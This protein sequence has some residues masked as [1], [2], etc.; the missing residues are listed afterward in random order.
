M[1]KRVLLYGTMGDIGRTALENLQ[2]HGLDAALVD[3]PQN[4]FR[5]VWGYCRGLGKA[6]DA[7]GPDCVVPVGNPIAMARFR[8]ENGHR[9]PGVEFCV[10]SEEKVRLLDSK[11]QSYG[12]AERLGILQPRRFPSATAVPEGVP[13][14]FKR[15]VS[16][17]G[18]GVHLPR[19]LEA[20]AQLIAHQ[21]PG[22]PY[23]IEE[24]I[25]GTDYSIDT[26]R[27]NG[28]CLFS[29]YRCEKERG[30]CLPSSKR[31]IV[32][33]PALEEVAGRILDSIDYQGV[34]GFDFMV[35]AQGEAYL[36]ESNPRFTGG[37]RTQIEAGFEI[38]WLLIR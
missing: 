10:E 23:L 11:V 12:H 14:V 7:F 17:G 6:V 5:D 20:T 4:V 25:E 3:F 37:L 29:A 35:T 22:E 27:R 34:C 15:D 32:K 33:F 1:S 8:E 2:R 16:F 19:S 24:L 18:H 38:P 28:E 26:V 36:L 13:T 21:P 30:R 9:Y 31:E